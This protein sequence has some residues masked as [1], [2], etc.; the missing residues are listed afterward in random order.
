VSLVLES[1]TFLGPMPKMW[2][3]AVT[4]TMRCLYILDF[5]YHCT[6]SLSK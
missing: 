5:G 4:N 3:Y 6:I 2:T 1:G